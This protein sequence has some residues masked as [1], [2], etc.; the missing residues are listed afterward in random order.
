VRFDLRN[1]RDF[2]AGALFALIGDLTFV[3]SSHY[4]MGSA[5]RMGPGYFP[6]MLGLL[7]LFF[8]AWVMIRGLVAGGKVGGDW[9][10]R[11]L[12]FV[13]L[14][15]LAFGALMDRVGLVPALVVSFV[16]AAR[17]SDE[18]RLR[19]VLIAGVLVSTVSAFLF[20]YL[21]KLPY[22]ILPGL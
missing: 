14:A 22:R 18:F 13:T 11:P 20:V 16:L 8:G 7:L 21:L 10:W 4:P 1:N 15:I 9:A 6:T 17:A 12:A 3:F 5:A 2:I 19:P